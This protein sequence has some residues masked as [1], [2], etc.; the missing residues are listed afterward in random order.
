MR[1]SGK[2]N[3]KWSGLNRNQKLFVFFAAVL[4]VCV[5]LQAYSLCSYW[6]GDAEYERVQKLAVQTASENVTESDAAA[7]AGT[8]SRAETEH[9]G[10]Q[11][12][13]TADEVPAESGSG[14]SENAE[15]GEQS[16]AEEETPEAEPETLADLSDDTLL[17]IDFEALL[18]ENPDTV[19]WID[20][21]GQDVS[22]PIVQAEDNSRYLDY[23]FE[24]E[25]SVYGAIFLD[26]RNQGLMNDG[27]TVIYGH[28]MRNGSMFGFLK[29][30]REKEYYEKY[31]YF[32]IYTPGQAYRCEIIACARLIV[33]SWHYRVQLRSHEVRQ[34][35]IDLICGAADYEI[36]FEPALDAPLVLLS[37]CSGSDHD[38]RLVVLARARKYQ[39]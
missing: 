1:T 27:N 24:G 6:R 2:W 34:A 13:E 31:P 28:N 21:P 11:S 23:S 12:A 9:G 25:K 20:F 32:N 15:F 22:Y 7:D 8:I 17:T 33:E 5:S 38:Y 39:D 18:E 35:Y 4:A 16:L 30:Y 26:Y 3:R 14:E 37:T 19:A 29:K 10:D 36:P